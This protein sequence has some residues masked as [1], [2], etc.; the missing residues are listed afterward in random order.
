[1]PSEDEIWGQIE[2]QLVELKLK[3]KWKEN[4][5]KIKDKVL[6]KL[7]HYATVDP[8]RNEIVK[9][10]VQL[11]EEWLEEVHA[12]Y[13]E[14]RQ[15]QRL[16]RTPEFVRAVFHKAVAPQIADGLNFANGLITRA[17]EE[18]AVLRGFRPLPWGEWVLLGHEARLLDYWLERTE[19]E[20]TELEHSKEEVQNAQPTTLETFSAPPEHKIE[21]ARTTQTVPP[22]AAPAGTLSTPLLNRGA[23]CNQIIEQMKQIRNLSTSKDM[24]EIRSDNPHWRVWK[25]IEG[26]VFSQK[27]RDGFLQPNQWPGTVNYATSLLTRYFN[28]CEDTIKRWRRN[29]RGRAHRSQG[30]K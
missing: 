1:V 17:S 18:I 5:P 10:G 24:Q 15:K 21:Q 23:F 9:V 20:A 2:H 22:M 19:D 7:G 28:V 12:T 25:M 8:L 3:R 16:E 29:E 14:V 26:Q 6:G 27:D 4:L 11:L 13:E 30:T